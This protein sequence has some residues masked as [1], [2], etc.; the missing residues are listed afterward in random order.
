MDELGEEPGVQEN[1]PITLDLYAAVGERLVSHGVLHPGV[2]GEDEV[3]GGPGPQKDHERRE[4]VHP[5]PESSFSEEE[6]SHE[7][8]LQEEGERSL[9]RQSLGDYAPG[10]GG[11]DGPVGPEL[12]LHRDTRDHPHDEGYREDLAP[13]AR[14]LVVELVPVAHVARLQDEDEHRQPH[15]ERGEEVVVD[16]GEGE[17][18]AAYEYGIIQDLPPE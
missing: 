14:A 15:R 13:E 7:G 9:H 3:G 8:G 12:K 18:P 5:L 11:E 16:D 2:G 4:P 17:L 1:G 10:E 6:Q